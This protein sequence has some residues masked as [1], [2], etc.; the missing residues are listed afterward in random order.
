[1][2]TEEA[3]GKNAVSEAETAAWEWGKEDGESA[4]VVAKG[5]SVVVAREDVGEAA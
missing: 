1:M 5:E 4:N 2:E 3:A